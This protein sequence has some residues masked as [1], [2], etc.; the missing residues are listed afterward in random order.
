MKNRELSD[1]ASAV[2]RFRER[3]RERGLVKK[4]VWIRPE[5][6]ARLT[7]I[8]HDLRTPEGVSNSDRPAWTLETLA[9]A[10]STSPPG[11][12]GLLTVAQIQGAEPSLRVSVSVPTLGNENEYIDVLLA[13]GGEQILVET[14]LW[15][16]S[17]IRDVA[18]FN[19]CVLRTHKFIPLATFSIID[20]ADE[21]YYTIFGSLYARSLLS[22]VLFEIQAVADAS[23]SAYMLY[24]EYLTSAY[25]GSLQSKEVNH[26]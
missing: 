6:A 14:L 19:D 20:I 10:L 25:L 23:Q 2:R 18:E 15:P 3:Q 12:A 1:T 11:V 24:G 8:E 21:P 7:Q 4:D 16:A 17:A 13:I 9:T 26:G 5:H 22:S